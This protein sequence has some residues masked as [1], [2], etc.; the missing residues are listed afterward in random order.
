MADRRLA[1]PTTLTNPN[2]GESTTFQ[3]GTAESELPDW[4][5]GKIDN[6][7]AWVKA[8]AVDEESEEDFTSAGSTYENM[9]VQELVDLARSEGVDL[10]SSARKAEIIA[11]LE[12]ADASDNE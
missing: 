1:T 12:A 3:P 7:S 2:S 9:T 6:D 5:E 11:A 8:G 10:P 4:A